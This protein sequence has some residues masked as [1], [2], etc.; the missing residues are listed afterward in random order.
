MMK[1]QLLKWTIVGFC[2]VLG[3]TALGAGQVS[4]HGYITS[5]GSR[6]YLG[7]NAFTNDTGQKPLNTNVG[8][9]QY[10]VSYTHLTLPTICSV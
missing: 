2:S 1:K 5:P 4:A 3:V 8:Q 10:A 7:S 6:A 9:V